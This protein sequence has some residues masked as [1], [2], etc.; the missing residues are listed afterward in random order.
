MFAQFPP[1]VCNEAGSGRPAAT[2]RHQVSLWQST[3]TVR[4]SAEQAWGLS[5]LQVLV[6]KAGR[7]RTPHSTGLSLG[8]RAGPAGLASGTWV[9]PPPGPHTP[10]CGCWLSPRSPVTPCH[11]HAHSDEARRQRWPHPAL[12]GDLRPEELTGAPHVLGTQGPHNQL[13]CRQIQGHQWSD[14]PE[15][16]RWLG[17]RTKGAVPVLHGGGLGPREQEDWLARALGHPVTG[18]EAGPWGG[19]PRPRG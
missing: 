5:R 9:P 1:G 10:S 4:P 14:Q 6:I 7:R 2:S 17:T 18:A 15:G 13:L 19:M 8:L 3:E 11:G 12:R 16:L